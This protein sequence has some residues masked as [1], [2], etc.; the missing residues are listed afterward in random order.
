M[1][2]SI[3]KLRDRIF[4][5]SG[6]YC[7]PFEEYYSHTNCDMWKWNYPLTKYANEKLVLNKVGDDVNASYVEALNTIIQILEDKDKEGTL[8]IDR[9]RPIWNTLD[10]TSKRFFEN[11][12]VQ[13]IELALWSFKLLYGKEH[14]PSEVY[15]LVNVELSK[16]N[17]S[18][19]MERENIFLIPF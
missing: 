19:S 4:E 8:I 12:Y 5:L 15:D 17:L 2:E 7:E 9:T 13:H 14:T 3:K 10:D 16:N 11:L 18:V 6:T 1:L